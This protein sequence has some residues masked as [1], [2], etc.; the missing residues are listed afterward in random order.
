MTVG[1]RIK[2]RRKEL[3]LSADELAEK[4]SGLGELSEFFCRISC[5]ALDAKEHEDITGFIL[6]QAGAQGVFNIVGKFRG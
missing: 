5:F 3:G 1:E 2:Q 6:T 4:L